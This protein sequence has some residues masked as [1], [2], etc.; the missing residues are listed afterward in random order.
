MRQLLR[1]IGLLP[2]VYVDGPPGIV[3]VKEGLQK[4]KREM[5][6]CITSIVPPPSPSAP[7]ERR[8][9]LSGVSSRIRSRS[10]S[11]SV[12]PQAHQAGC[13][14][15][16]PKYSEKSKLDVFSFNPEASWVKSF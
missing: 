13:K 10:L 14:Q 7:C 15:N 8:V 2:F 6:G 12:Q 9:A 5:L 16:P 11:L 1:L 3:L 4:V